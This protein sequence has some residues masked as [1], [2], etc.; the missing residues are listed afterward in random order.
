MKTDILKAFLLLVET[1]NYSQTARQLGISQ[2]AVAARLRTL[3]LQ[4]GA[5]LLITQGHQTVLTEAGAVLLPYVQQLV[6]IAEKAHRAVAALKDLSGAEL[7]VGAGNTTGTYLL[8]HVVAMFRQQHPGVRVRI[9]IGPSQEVV[10]RVVMNLCDIGVISL[11]PAHYGLC[12]RPL[13]SYRLVALV[14]KGHELARRKSVPLREL[15][16]YPLIL[17]E[18]RSEL[19][20]NVEQ[21]FAQIGLAASELNIVM[22]LNT[23]EAIKVAVEAGLGV[24]I[25]SECATKDSPSLSV[26]PITDPPLKADLYVVHNTAALRNVASQAFLEFLQDPALAPRLTALCPGLTW[27]QPATGGA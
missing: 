16:R 7:V 21:Y 15:G 22:E 24:S 2:P 23:P 6:A 4:V 17:R 12:T 13:G 25:L 5:K 26:V 18:K 3:E 10:D 27:E 8:P 19:R 9:E 20:R 11:L 1:G 14:P